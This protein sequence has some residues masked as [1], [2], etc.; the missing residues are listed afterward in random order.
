VVLPAWQQPDAYDD[1]GAP[2]A[3]ERRADDA[4]DAGAVRRQPMGVVFWISVGWL[5]LITLAAIL[6][7]VL[8]IRPPDAI[9]PF[10]QLAAPFHGGYLLGSDN[11]GRD[12]LS[13][14]IYG[15]RVSLI[16]G[17]ASMV[18]G[19]GIGA[20]LGLIAGFIRGRPE[21]VIMWAVDVVLSFPALV[22]LISVVAFAGTS[23]T[24][25]SLVLGFLSI[26]VYARITR[27]HTLTVGK[28]EFITAARA[29]GVPTRR[30]IWH[31]VVPN[32]LPQVLSYGLIAVGVVIVVEGSLSFLGLSVSAPTPSWG[33]IIASGQEFL[34]QDPSLVLVPAAVMCLTV[35]ALNLAGDTLRRRYEAAGRSTL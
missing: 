17:V 1:G 29:I 32:V 25:I 26:P 2:R 5:S 23:L 6:A 27:A 3:D 7:P 8:P 33:G 11:L 15:A 20:S 22:L 4:V 34:S 19:L 13:R 16:V 28:R 18:I 12:V 30:I 21:A 31:E 24:T 10:R 14:L 9:D 35:L